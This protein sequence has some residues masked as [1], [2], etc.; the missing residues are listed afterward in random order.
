M[1]GWRDREGQIQGDP[2]LRIGQVVGDVGNQEGGAGIAPVALRIYFWL[3]TYKAG[4]HLQ[5]LPLCI[6]M[7]FDFFFF[8][9]SPWVKYIVWR[10][11]QNILE[12]QTLPL[13]VS[14]P[15]Y[16]HVL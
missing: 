15:F 2:S 7:M 14:L 6:S 3:L 16:L 10:N 8:F 13:K 1:R 12:R 11:L 9:S 4:K 5:N